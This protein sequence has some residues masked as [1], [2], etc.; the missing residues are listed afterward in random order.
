ML[1]NITFYDFC[2]F[3]CVAVNTVDKLQ[4]LLWIFAVLLSITLHFIALIRLR[5]AIMHQHTKNSA[6]IDASDFRDIMFLCF[7]DGNW[8]PSWIF[9][10]I[11]FYMLKTG[12]YIEEILRF[13]DFPNGRNCHLGYLKSQNFI[14][15]HGPEVGHASPFQ[16]SSKLVNYLIS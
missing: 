2:S 3:W 9:K 15:Y 5:R 6:E 10:S 1:S 4:F 11:K 7:P 14:G 13:F 16:I 12:P 8:P